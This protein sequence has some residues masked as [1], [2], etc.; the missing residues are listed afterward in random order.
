MKLVISLL[1]AFSLI[2]IGVPALEVNAQDFDI[3]NSPSE[4]PFGILEE[5]TS[6]PTGLTHFTVTNNSTYPVN[7]TIGGSDMTGGVTW[8][9]ADD[10]VAGEDIY[11]LKAGLAG[12]TYN[13][14]V[15][16]NGPYNTLIS[17]L[18]SQASQSWGLELLSPTS[19]SDGTQKSGTITLTATQI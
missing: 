8:T 1:A 5:S 7:I 14:T 11:G 4:Y 13:V 18:A 2:V 16:K 10:A 15:K 17:N 19:F 12:G 3:L 6:Y 9:L